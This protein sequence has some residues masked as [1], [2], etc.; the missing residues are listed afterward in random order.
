VFENKV[1]N[2]IFW[3]QREKITE[4]WGNLCDN[5]AKED[6][7]RREHSTHGR[8]MSIGCDKEAYLYGRDHHKVLGVDT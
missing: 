5:Q 3:L 6:A 4:I 7:M 1:L 8:E 2:G